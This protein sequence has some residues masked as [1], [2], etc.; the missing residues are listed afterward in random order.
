[1]GKSRLHEDLLGSLPRID[2][3]VAGGVAT[4]MA[5][6]GSQWVLDIVW[7]ALTRR[8]RMQSRRQAQPPSGQGMQHARRRSG[9]G[10]A[11]RA[12]SI[13]EA[14]AL[15][16]GSSAASSGRKRAQ[17]REKRSGRRETRGE[18]QPVRDK[19]IDEAPWPR[20]LGR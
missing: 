2:P 16:A 10:E 15:A 9:T 19:G 8:V 6:G 5:S 1:M 17:G 7:V 11:V 3:A 18:G 20:I 13:E 14:Q 4:E 12:S